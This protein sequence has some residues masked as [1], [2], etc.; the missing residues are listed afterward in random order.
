MPENFNLVNEPFTLIT[1]PHS[2]VPKLCHQL[3]RLRVSASQ[4][5][6]GFQ[7]AADSL[8]E[9]WLIEDKKSSI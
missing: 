2:C 4:M 5:F 8:K 1:L 3:Q 6:P 9:R 7:G